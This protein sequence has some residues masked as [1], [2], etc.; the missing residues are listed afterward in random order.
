[1]YDAN[2]IIQSLRK[3]RGTKLFATGEYSYA[4]RLRAS[5]TRSVRGMRTL[6][7]FARL[8]S[9]RSKP[10]ENTRWRA[11]RYS[12]KGADEIQGRLAAL[13]DIHLASRGGDMPSLRLG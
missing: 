12:P 2:P 4:C 6:H 9:L 11:M 7:R 3:E 10:Q 8:A 5:S 1:M 13:D